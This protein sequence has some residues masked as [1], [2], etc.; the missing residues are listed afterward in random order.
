MSVQSV[1]EQNSSLKFYT[2]FTETVEGS[3]TYTLYTQTL[4]PGRWFCQSTVTAANITA[5]DT[6]NGLTVVLV[7][8]ATATSNPTP[9]VGLSDMF[10][11]EFDSGTFNNLIQFPVSGIFYSDT[12]FDI[13]VVAILETSDPATEVQFGETIGYDIPSYFQCVCL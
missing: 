2:N 6:I 7:S 12:A 11:E 4:P 13:S 8:T 9:A 10:V 3:D 1:L 5:G